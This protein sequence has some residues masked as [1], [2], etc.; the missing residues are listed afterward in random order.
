M[1]R[2]R[3]KRQPKFINYASAF[4]WLTAMGSSFRGVAEVINR[5][6]FAVVGRWAWVDGVIKPI[7]PIDVTAVTATQGATIG[8]V[9]SDRGVVET[10][11][12]EFTG[13]VVN[14][15]PRQRAPWWLGR[16]GLTDAAGWASVNPL[17]YE[18]TMPGM[19]GVHVIGDSQ[20]T[21]QPK[22]AHMANSQAKVC[23][24]A[25]LR[26]FADLPTDSEERMANV[27]TNS[28]CYS[29]I[30]IDTASWLTANF[31]YNPASG[32]MELQHI[33]EA[34]RPSNGNFRQMF[35]WASNLFTDSFS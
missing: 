3:V 7:G 35:G 10:S 19:Q 11:V 8:S 33:G 34:S 15:I 5:A 32:A 2:D 17:T 16:S 23:A 27:T 31:A 14:L 30:T 6:S 1:Y 24:D 13:D 18:S 22:S 21:G 20:G 4:A 12:G 29:P 25:I 9:D 26:M 28:A